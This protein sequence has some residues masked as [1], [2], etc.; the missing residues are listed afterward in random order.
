MGYSA[1]L[2]H[3]RGLT[4]ARPTAAPTATSC[5]SHRFCLTRH[6]QAKL[7]QLQELWNMRRATAWP[8]SNDT[9]NWNVGTDPTACTKYLVAHSGFLGPYLSYGPDLS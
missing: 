6:F 9:N 2:N 1:W 3:Q 7:K 5:L 8:T 4:L